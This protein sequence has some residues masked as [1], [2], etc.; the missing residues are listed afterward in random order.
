M[1]IVTPTTTEAPVIIPDPPVRDRVRWIVSIHI[2]S[3]A[4]CL[5]FVLADRGLLINRGISSFFD[6]AGQFPSILCC[7]PIYLCPLWLL[8]EIV[9][10]RVTG[11]S[12]VL[13]VI[14]E[15]LLC[16]THWTVLLPAIGECAP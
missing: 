15:T 10:R 3:I 2:I 9:R 5:M 8:V 12:A 14:A 1:T 6:D 13:A 7:L 16:W 11:R 4:A